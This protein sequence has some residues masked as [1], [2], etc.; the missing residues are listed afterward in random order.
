MPSVSLSVLAWTGLTSRSTNTFRKE[1]SIKIIEYELLPP[2]LKRNKDIGVK[3]T[4]VL[5]SR[6]FTKRP[7]RRAP[8]VTDDSSA[9]GASSSNEETDTPPTSEGE[10]EAEEAASNVPK[11]ANVRVKGRLKGNRAERV[12]PP[13]E[14]RTHLRRL[15]AREAEMC[16]LLFARHGRTRE[17]SSKSPVAPPISPDMFFMDAVAVTPTRFRPAARM[18]DDLYENPQNSLLTSIINTCERLKDINQRLIDYSKA[19]QDD[20]VMS[21]VTKLQGARSFE[22]LLQSVLQLQHDVNSFMDSTKNPTLMRQGKLPPQGVKQLLE[23]KEGLFRKHMMVSL[24]HLPPVQYLINRA[25][26]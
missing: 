9:S 6:P 24:T 23:K 21:A 20:G 1:K 2:E 8:S 17:S 22:L 5:R 12:V 10:F 26:E 4:D 7:A 16:A 13:A 3:R 15:F 14:V 25:S 11:S 19:E 18:G